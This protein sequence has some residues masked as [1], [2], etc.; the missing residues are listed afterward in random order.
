MSLVSTSI[1]RQV[2][3]TVGVILVLLFGLISLFRTPI[4]LT[5]EVARP[6]ITVSTVWRGASP[7]EV[8]KEII[9]RQED[10]LKGVE[11]VLEMDSESRDSEGRIVLTFQPGT[12]MDTALVKVSNRLSQV[13]DLPLDA[14]RPVV[15]TV[16]TED[17]P[18]AWFILKPL[19][20]ND[21]PIY[22]YEIFAEDFIKA[23]F[24]RVP[25]V[26][27]SNVLG[28]REREMQVVVDPKRLSAYG[29]TLQ[30]FIQSLQAENVNI[31]GGSFDEGKRRY[32]VRT[33]AEFVEPADVERVAL[34]TS[35]GERIFIGD[36]AT[37]RFGYERPDVSVRQN[38]EPAVAV[39]AQRE[40]GSNVLE[41]MAG[42]KEA[43]RELNEGVLKEEG[44]ELTQVYDETDYIE[45]AIDLVQQNLWIGGT[46][47][48]L[49]LLLFLRSFSSTLIVATAIPI[50]LVGTFIVMALL[51][52][53]INVI[54]LAGLA[55]AVGMV[56]DNAIVVLEN[57]FR[58]RQMGKSRKEAALEGTRE[59]WGAVLSSTLTTIAVFLP[60]LFIVEE[61]GQLFR[62]IALAIC[63][64]VAL[65]LVVSVS[66]IPS[67][68]ARILGEGA[69]A[70]GEGRKGRHGFKDLFGAVPLAER[71]TGGVA[72][73]NYKVS[74]SL[75]ASLLVVFLL[76]GGAIGTAWLLLPKPE[77]LPTGNRNLIIGLLIP[78]PGYN[79]DEFTRIGQQL[80][81]EFSP[82]WQEGESNPRGLPS[83]SN[84]FY[85]ARGRQIFM[86][87]RST[88]PG[89]I[90][91]LIPFARE[92]LSQVAGMIAIV[93]QSSLFDRTLSG[94][95]NIDVEFSGADLVRLVEIGGRAFGAVGDAIPGAQ[96]RPIPS[97]DLGNPELRVLPDRVRLADLGITARELG[98]VVDSFIDGTRAG[99]VNVEGTELDL[100]VMAAEEYASRTQELESLLLR[101]REGRTV[102][103][104]SIARVRLVAGPEQINHSERQRTITIQ[105]TPPEEVP[106]EAAMETIQMQVIEELRRDGTL[107]S[108]IRVRLAGT[109]D[110]LRITFDVL[111]WNFLL[112]LIIT[113]LLM[114]ALFESFFYPFVIIMSVPLAMAGGLLGLWLVNI[115]ITYQAMDVLTMLGFII[116][117]GTVVNNAILIV[118]QALNFM[119]GKGMDNHEALRE[120]VRS[121]VRPIFMSVGTS[122]FGMLPLVLFPGPG[123]ELYRGL[124]SVVVGGLAV[125]TIFTLFLVPALFSLLMDL[126]LK[127]TGRAAKGA[128][129]GKPD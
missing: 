23:R 6:E 96:I 78:P 38:G 114:A 7:E 37:V 70:G 110:K 124:G 52:R 29:F 25:G 21:R 40:S 115:L 123:S 47:A 3:V 104:G 75:P 18:I 34:T 99:T 55:F 129:T 15:S 108:D 57:I 10:E 93:Q 85:V 83:L 43:L 5:P 111:K 17:Q 41:V 11:G 122:V 33:L 116:L 103:L 101:N 13:R 51:G 89:R 16:N 117:I 91:E 102:P 118:H 79:I 66:V 36:V 126:R 94:G 50:S 82:L 20:G 32:I 72:E 27:R 107:G 97:L 88:E 86:G 95:R 87:M 76:T 63:G 127:L 9:Q 65:S 81:A 84:F 1:D 113:Y 67:F 30:E 119:R 60:I 45:S 4:Q 77:Y 109:A 12:N 62:D 80:E 121:R 92:N 44:L 73:F 105:V 8:E 90:R 58:H 120:S 22:T 14:E 28:A 48:V 35:S 24:E 54:S 56:V 46:L 125:S 26:A 74:R 19:P 71:F 2:S 64:A 128:S 49:V 61:T 42:L 106:L 100:N 98:I 53:T 69:S 39:N 68:A 31:S 112:A 59:V